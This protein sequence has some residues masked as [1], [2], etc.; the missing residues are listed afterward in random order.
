MKSVWGVWLFPTG[1]CLSGMNY[2]SFF[3]LKSHG[4]FFTLET[5]VFCIFLKETEV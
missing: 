5:I 4:T 2:Q 3:F 1:M